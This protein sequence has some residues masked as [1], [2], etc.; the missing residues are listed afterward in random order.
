MR[1]SFACLWL[2]LAALL[3]ACGDFSIG[4]WPTPEVDHKPAPRDDDGTDNYLG[5]ESCDGDDDDADGSIDEG[6][7]CDGGTR[8]CVGKGSAGCGAGTQECEDG[9]WQE[10]S[11][12]S[13]PFSDP[14]TPALAP[15]TEAAVQRGTAPIRVTVTATPG[16]EGTVVPEVDVALIA[17]SPEMKIHGVARDDGAWPDE[18]AGDGVSTVELPNVFG[19][20]VPEQLLRLEA[21]AV[22][23]ERPVAGVAE[24]ELLEP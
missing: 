24:T 19:P 18:V 8:A 23:D 7:P 13:A 15:E 5:E 14:Q 11:G 20:G 10:C 21:Q 9:I 16:C 17:E 4:T 2:V 22:I 1:R 6:C 12:L 3:G